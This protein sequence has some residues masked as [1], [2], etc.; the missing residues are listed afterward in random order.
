M[1]EIAVAIC[2]PLPI[3]A[4]KS[5]VIFLGG[6]VSVRDWLASRPVMFEMLDE[7]SSG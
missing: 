4:G 2:P 5:V 6:N 7:F 1:Y 3:G